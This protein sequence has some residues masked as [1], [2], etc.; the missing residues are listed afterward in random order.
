MR[1]NWDCQG[2]QFGGRKN[3][4]RQKEVEQA[5]EKFIMKHGEPAAVS[6]HPGEMQ[7]FMLNVAPVLYIKTTPPGHY[8]IWR[9]NEHDNL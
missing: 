4:E 3:E 7:N 5:V 1:D 9:K 2:H 8:Y 6:F